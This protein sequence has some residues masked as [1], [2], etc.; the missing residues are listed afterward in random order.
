MHFQIPEEKKKRFILNTDAKNEVDDQFAIVHAL[1]TESFDLRGIIAAHFGELKSL[2]SMED[3]YD[4]IMKLLALMDWKE[5]TRV[6]KGAKHALPDENTP[7]DSAGARLIIEEAMKDDPRPLYV[8][9]LGPL[10]D[11]ASALL[12]EPEIAEKDIKVI[13]I[14]GGPWPSGD[15]EYNLKNDIVAANVI[16]KSKLELW[17]IP[18]NVY[19]MMPVSYATMAKR[20]APYGEIGRY[21]V[22]NVIAHNN[23]SVTGPSEYRVLGDSPAIGVMLY[24]DC[25]RWQWKPA[26]E[27]DA[28]MKYV[29]TG[30]NRPIK[31]YET[32]DDYF[33][34]EDF[35]AKLQDYVESSKD[36]PSKE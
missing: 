32:I 19:R 7:E 11:M 23:K 9:F 2:H 16:M 3:S 30:K 31:V 36:A 22:E 20:V 17:Q 18:R 5:E 28:Q 25:G 10:T 33:I 8:A 35:Y 29:H 34:M 15:S 27:F 26:P 12:L 4:E 21:L 24:E 13:W 14:G 6:E 1:L